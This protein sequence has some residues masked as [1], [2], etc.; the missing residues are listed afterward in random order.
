NASEKLPVAWPRFDKGRD[1]RM[2]PSRWPKAT[3]P[4]KLVIVE[5]WALGLKPQPL[6][7]LGTPVNALE[8]DEDDDGR[9]RKWVNKQ[10]R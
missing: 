4:P 7:A 10:L 6:A 8:R 9:W 5:G 1:T 2:P 3:R